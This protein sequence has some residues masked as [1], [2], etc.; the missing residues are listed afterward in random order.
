MLDTFK[1]YNKQRCSYNI[2][3]V[4]IKYSLSCET[5]LRLKLK[6]AVKALLRDPSIKNDT[7]KWSIEINVFLNLHRFIG[8]LL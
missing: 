3:R 2:K 4:K 7:F 8:Y 1:N 5:S 6:A